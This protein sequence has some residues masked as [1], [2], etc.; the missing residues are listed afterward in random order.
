MTEENKVNEVEEN[1]KITKDLMDRTNYLYFKRKRDNYILFSS[2]TIMFTSIAVLLTNFYNFK[3][4]KEQMFMFIVDREKEI[5]KEDF[6]EFV[7]DSE[8]LSA[9]VS[10]DNK[11]LG[12]VCKNKIFVLDYKTKKIIFQQK[13]T[14]ILSL[15]Y[16]DNRQILCYLKDSKTNTLVFNK[17]Q[18]AKLEDAELKKYKMFSLDFSMKKILFGIDNYTYHSILINK[19]I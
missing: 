8:I 11:Y 19:N 10:K 17:N 9:V 16:I 2:L 4:A 6:K 13:N 15:L 5:S 3:S 18:E 14:N 1:E 12:V 7:F